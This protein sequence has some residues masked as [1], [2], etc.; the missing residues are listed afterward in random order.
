MQKVA[1]NPPHSILFRPYLRVPMQ[2]SELQLL[3]C[4]QRINQDFDLILM[5]QL[6]KLLSDAQH[7]QAQE[8]I[9]DFIES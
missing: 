2:P 5:P 1:I 9:S 7:I 4:H 6:S 8:P 3:I